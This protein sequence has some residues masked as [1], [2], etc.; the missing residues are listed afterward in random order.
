MSGR[1]RGSPVFAHHTEQI[2]AELGFDAPARDTLAASGAVVRTTAP[3]A[4]R[5]PTDTLRRN[6]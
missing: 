1:G 4:G 2:L 5:L 3:E 6:V